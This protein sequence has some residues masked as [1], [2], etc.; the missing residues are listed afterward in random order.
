M[1]VP[2]LS[3]EGAQARILCAN[4]PPDRFRVTIGALVPAADSTEE[5]RAQGITIQSVAVR[6][7]LDFNG[8]RMLRRTVRDAGTDLLHT[9]GVAAAR[10]A[11]FLVSTE[12]EVGNRPRLVVSGASSP[13]SGIGGWVA[14]RQVRKADRVIA[15]TRA[16]GERYRRMQVAAER[17][18]RISPST[19]RA[20]P[21]KHD[22]ERSIRGLELPA[23]ARLI[24]AE[25]HSEGG[26]GSRDVIAAFDMLRY[27]YSQLHLAYLGAGSEAT[28]LEQ[29]GRALAFDDFRI[30]FVSGDASSLAARRF[31]ELSVIVKPRGGIA[32]A[33]A[34]MSAGKPVIGWWNPDLAEIVDEGVTGFLVPLGDRAGLAGKIKL[35]LDDP[36]LAA[37]LGEAGR[38]RASERFDLHR[39]TEQFARVYTELLG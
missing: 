32:E 23:D 28:G 26:I 21:V 7:I 10:A 9:W 5:L 17:L 39:M 2:D 4:L 13:G 36:R 6:H 38:A 25:G 1:L 8:I 14:A 35:L 22:R 18:T 12:A 27:D 31:A 11:R 30:R 3:G 19:D 24:V 34:A 15:V 37:R 29:F 20:I 16:E 33:L